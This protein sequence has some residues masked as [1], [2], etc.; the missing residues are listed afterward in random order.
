MSDARRCLVVDG[1]PLVRLGVR[2]LLDDR[3]EVE[4]AASGADA[5]E[6]LTDYGEFDVAIVDLGRGAH[7]GAEKSGASV[8]RALRKASPGLGIVAHGSRAERHAANE[9]MEAGASAYV[10]KSSPAEALNRAVDAAAAAE[11]FMD[12]AADGRKGV[13]PAVTRRQR[14]ILQLIADGHST[15]TAAERLGLSAETVRTHT[16]AALARLEARDRAHAV[17]ISLRSS[18]ID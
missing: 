3:F 12:P 10:A 2:R 13:R 18:L 7:D 16:K 11:T 6:M 1:H 4:E 5:L 9:A 14:Q 15:S 8:V 17:A